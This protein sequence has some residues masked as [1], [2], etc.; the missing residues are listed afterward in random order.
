VTA[1]LIGGSVGLLTLGVPVA[2]ALLV[3]A[4]AAVLITGD[5]HPDILIQQLYASV[6]ST[7]LLAIPFF[8]FGGELMSR[9]GMSHR[10]ANMI[11][12]V[13][14]FVRGGLGIATVGASMFFSGMSGSAVADTAAIGSVTVP[15]M[16]AKGYGADFAG[17]LVATAG[18][19]GVIIPPSIPF[20]LYGVAT[21]LSVSELFIAGVIPGILVGLSLMAVVYVMAGR[22]GYGAVERV[23]LRE[24]LRRIWDG[25]AAIIM[26]ILILGG[27]M[28]GITTPT[29][30]AVIAVLWALFVG[31]LWYRTLTVSA[32]YASAKAAVLGS[33][34]VMLLLGASSAFTYLLN[35]EGIPDDIGNL[36]TSVA[37]SKAIFLLVLNGLLLVVGLAV[38]VVPAIT[39]LAPILAP[40]AIELDIDPIHFAMIFVLNL[41]IGTVT[42]PA[43]PTLVTASTIAGVSLK[44]LSISV[45]PF[46]AA[47]IFV[48]LLVTYIPELST[49]LPSISGD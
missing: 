6:N 23:T 15:M 34:A 49:W 20:I 46:M 25:L 30:A 4:F 44:R 40:I 14:G 48:L 39:V 32:I 26:P 11:L 3:A 17:G 29:E 24:G 45:L 2:V 13:I 36:L 47:E 31:L 33:A 38:D 35:L 12:A 1:L 10:I 41:V 27:I 18:T 43:A 8:L 42:P 9:S 22:R 28:T 21:D 16:K 19:I 37:D 5:G 7:T